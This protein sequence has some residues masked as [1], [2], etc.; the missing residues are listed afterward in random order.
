MTTQN[1]H[2]IIKNK[3]VILFYLNKIVMWSF[4]S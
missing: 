4:D 3:D 2:K 1:M